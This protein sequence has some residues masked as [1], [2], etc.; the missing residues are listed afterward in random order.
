MRGYLRKEHAY[1]EININ[2]SDDP[3]L[4]KDKANHCRRPHIVVVK[5]EIV[6]L[7]FVNQQA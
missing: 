6:Y 5:L 1:I 4:C 7:Q 2:S 3:P